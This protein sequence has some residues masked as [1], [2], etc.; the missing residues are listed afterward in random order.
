M[1]GAQVDR[2]KDGDTFLDANG[3]PWSIKKIT[4][5]ADIM[6]IGLDQSWDDAPN[7]TEA[8]IAWLRPTDKSYNAKGSEHDPN[9]IAGTPDDLE[10]LIEAWASANHDSMTTVTKVVQVP[11]P[12]AQV[13][14]PRPPPAA[15]GG[16][17]W[18]LFALAVFV[19]W[20]LDKVERRSR[21]GRRK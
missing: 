16:G 2:L 19:A 1:P 5:V 11:V 13:S 17:S 7:H 4:D 12:A 18:W 15:T 10:E 9:L 14:P 20:N 21:R 8:W 3:V 6:R